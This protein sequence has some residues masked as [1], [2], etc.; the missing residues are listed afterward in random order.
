MREILK[1]PWANEPVGPFVRFLAWVFVA[2]GLFAFGSAAY[3]TAKEGLPTSMPLKAYCIILSTVYLL[4]VFL[5]VGLRGR[6]PSG[7]V[8]WK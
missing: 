7:W 2:C 8:P 6:A 4:A 3:F 5:F 1:A